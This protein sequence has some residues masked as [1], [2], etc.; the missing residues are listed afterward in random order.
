MQNQATEI[1]GKESRMLEKHGDLQ[2]W[3]L[4]TDQIPEF[5]RYILT[6]YNQAFSDGEAAV[7]AA[8]IESQSELY[9]HRARVCG[10]RHESGRLIG[11][12]GL[13]VKDLEDPV[14]PEFQLPTQSYYDLRTE[15][16]LEIMEAPE[17]RFLFNGWRTAV[18]KDALEELRLDRNR[19][20][21]IF[22]LLMRGLTL[23]FKGLPEQYLGIA[24]MEKLVYKYHRRVGIPWKILGDPIHFWGRDRYPCGFRFG[25][26]IEYMRTHHPERYEFLN[27]PIQS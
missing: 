27:A 7:P 1:S 17:V 26:Y 9:F 16:I 23:D 12:W 11:T 8:D 6:V 13:V 18:D 10:V 20:I 25:E 4:G 5:N 3:L 22:D 15:S 24:D 19:S 21:F 14:D 2:L